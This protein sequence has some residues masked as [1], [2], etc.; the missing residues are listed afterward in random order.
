MIIKNLRANNLHEVSCE[1]LHNESIGK[2]GLS[3]SGKS[4][5]CSTIADESLKR[6]GTLLTKSEY[7][8]LFSDK[9]HSNNSVQS[10]TE[11]PLI[12]Y[13]GK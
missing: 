11:R 12:L 3:G 1:I 8:F 10:A 9:V 2:A 5:F 6:I 13:R 7:R 4:P